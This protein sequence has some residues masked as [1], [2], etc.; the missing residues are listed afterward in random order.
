MLTLL[1]FFVSSTLA[2]TFHSFKGEH[3]HFTVNSNICGTGV[4]SDRE[5]SGYIHIPYVTDDS[6]S[7]HLLKYP[8]LESIIRTPSD[9]PLTWVYR[10]QKRL[11]L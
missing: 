3:G 5:A 8:S 7:R 10:T 11:Q 4:S 1:F 9:T 2:R 6:K